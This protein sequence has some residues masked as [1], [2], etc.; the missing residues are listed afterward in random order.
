MEPNLEEKGAAE[1][2]HNWR[3]PPFKQEGVRDRNLSSLYFGGKEEVR[4]NLQFSRRLQ[5]ICLSDRYRG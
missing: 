1:Y 3:D 5:R 2:K 4:R